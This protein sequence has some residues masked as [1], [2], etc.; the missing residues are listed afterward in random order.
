MHI[1]SFSSRVDRI[2]GMSLKLMV[3][4]IWDFSVQS[5]LL[6]QGYSVESWVDRTQMEYCWCY[7]EKQA[8]SLTFLKLLF[9][10]MW[11][12]LPRLIC[13]HWNV[14][15]DIFVWFLWRYKIMLPLFLF[16]I[17][18]TNFNSPGIRSVGPGRIVIIL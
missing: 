10:P 11:P 13:M 1:C 6:L 7:W 15:G 4:I 18:L 14:T 12:G 2:V 17:Y 16:S 3:Y 9:K 5:C 8:I